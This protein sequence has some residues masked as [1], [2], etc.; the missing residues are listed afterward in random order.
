MVEDKLLR[1][2]MSKGT[3][4]RLIISNNNFKIKNSIK[5]DIQNF[6]YNIAIKYNLPIEAFNEYKHKVLNYI[7]NLNF[8]T[9]YSTFYKDIK[10][11]IT[12][13]KDKFVIVYVDK[14]PGNFA[15]IC[16]YY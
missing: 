11:Q 12:E 10:K 1:D 3:K 7:F 5:K 4:H 16:K 9:E 8:K 14:V 6:L 2:I 13:L 15:I